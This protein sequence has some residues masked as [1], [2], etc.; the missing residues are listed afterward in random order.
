MNWWQTPLISAGTALVVTLLVEY[1]AKPWLEVRKDRI[2]N[3]RRAHRDYR[4]A[5]RKTETA[6]LKLVGVATGGAESEE[7]AR[8]RSAKLTDALDSLVEHYALVD[9][10]QAQDVRTLTKEAIREINRLQ[11]ALAIIV[12]TWP[13]LHEDDREE[14][15][16]FFDTNL[17]RLL[18]LIAIL[19]KLDSLSGGRRSRA[20]RRAS[21][22]VCTKYIDNP[23]PT[24]LPEEQ[25]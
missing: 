22:E 6:A 10:K 1:A 24:Y 14:G 15:V 2:L 4:I 7:V 23:F 9:I 12:N 11:N 5:L 8:E 13:K 20:K 19:Q 21:L 16:K 25:R 3:E 17:R 18:S